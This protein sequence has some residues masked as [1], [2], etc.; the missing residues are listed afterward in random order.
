MTSG[1]TLRFHLFVPSPF[2]DNAII[3]EVCGLK[4]NLDGTTLASGGN[5]NFL[6]LWEASMSGR[7]TNQHWE[8]NHPPRAV[9]IH[10]GFNLQTDGHPPRQPAGGAVVREENLAT[11]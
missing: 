4:W 2:T 5:E 10:R 11:R 7:Q 8:S 1:P 9:L 3:P 6:C